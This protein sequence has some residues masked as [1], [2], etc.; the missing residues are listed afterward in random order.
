MTA[1]SKLLGDLA[2]LRRICGS[3]MAI[4]WMICC[5]LNVRRILKS[6]NLKSADEAMGQG[7]FL[8][9]LRR[10]NC[11]FEI[12]GP[13]IV[14]GMREMY[15]RDTYFRGGKLRVADG[16]TVVDLGANIGNLTNMA[17]ACGPNV[18]VVAV[19]PS[20]ALN[21]LF[22]NSVNLN[23]GFAQRISLIR[24]FVG[25][26]MNDKMAA[27]IREDENYRDAPWI[28]EDEL[29]SRGNISVINFLKCDIEG[30]EYDLLHAGSRLLAMTERLAIEIHAFA[31]EPR[32][33]IAEI[34]SQGLETVLIDWDPDGTCTA[35][36]TRPSLG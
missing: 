18:R 20:R 11:S 16:D 27:V 3:R 13:A 34:N 22:W 1:I 5:F 19:E 24:S 14:S 8:I 9:R 17:L 26:P 31:G 25:G 30:G 21:D 33:L 15:A 32:K 36:F 4:K 23:C 35:L 7:P 10:Y 6:G 29:I 2:G 12:K 28:S